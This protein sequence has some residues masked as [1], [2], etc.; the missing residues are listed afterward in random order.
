MTN[1]T[2]TYYLKHFYVFVLLNVFKNVV[3]FLFVDEE[4]EL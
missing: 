1:I 2:V 3:R 4:T